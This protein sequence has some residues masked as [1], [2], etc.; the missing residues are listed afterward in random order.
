MQCCVS[1][2]FSCAIFRNASLSPDGSSGMPPRPF[3]GSAESGGSLMGRA[4]C[5]RRC[6]T[7]R[8]STRESLDGM[9]EFFVFMESFFVV[10]TTEGF[11]L[12][13]TEG[14]FLVM[15]EGFFLV[16]TEGFF[17]V[18]SEGGFFLVAMDGMG[19]FFTNRHHSPCATSARSGSSGME[20][21]CTKA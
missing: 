14:F 16:I 7:S 11:F 4:S 8:P 15:T 13:M 9:D 12:V 2:S 19:G 20:D 10:I 18:I 3:R 21:C 17:L 1:S 6:C 5:P